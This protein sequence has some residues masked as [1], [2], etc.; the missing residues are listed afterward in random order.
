[1]I[2]R[3]GC[4]GA[5]LLALAA[6]ACGQPPAAPK[7]PGSVT[8]SSGVAER[9][10]AQMRSKKTFWITGT[11]PWGAPNTARMTALIR[12]GT[13][14]VTASDTAVD[15]EGERHREIYVEGVT[16]QDMP[17]ETMP[18]GKKWTKYPYADEA[19]PYDGGLRLGDDSALDPAEPEMLRVLL[20]VS[21][22]GKPA[23]V[24][25]I[26]TTEYG[27]TADLA[28]LATAARGVQR[29]ILAGLVSAGVTSITWRLWLDG[30]QLPRRFTET[31][32]VPRPGTPRESMTEITTVEYRRW[33]TSDEIKA[34]PADQ[35]V[36][37][38]SEPLPPPFG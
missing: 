11:I 13:T 17:A 36:D 20:T 19:D 31:L 37:D 24:D 12:L 4:A 22:P 6:T 26:T 7:S 38:A 35:V 29:R 1:M 34:P 30:D 15:G 28:D 32:F 18:P 9:M 25:G 3:V 16:Y 5:V 21:G 33:G 27:G 8:P 2:R 10:A 23:T 14:G